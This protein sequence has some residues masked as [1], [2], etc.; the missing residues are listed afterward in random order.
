MGQPGDPSLWRGGR[1]E[2]GVGGGEVRCGLFV[3]AASI[4]CASSSSSSFCLWFEAITTRVRRSA[5]AVA[6]PSAGIYVFFAVS[7]DFAGVSGILETS[8]CCG[9]VQTSQARGFFLG[10]L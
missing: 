10:G 6:D 3:L 9:C 8:V 1:E 5:R 2:G 4:W 7:V